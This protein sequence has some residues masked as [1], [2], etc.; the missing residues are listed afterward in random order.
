[1]AINVYCAMPDHVH[2]LTVGTT[3]AV[4]LKEFVP[5]LKQQTGWD[6]RRERNARL[7]QEGYYDHVLRP[8]EGTAAVLAYIVNNPVRA[9]LVAEPLEY[10]FWGSFT[11]TREEIVALIVGAADWKPGD[12]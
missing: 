12:P 1:M 2:M 3:D 4:N 8:E 9:G 10:E 11:H 5:E 7:W 6:Y